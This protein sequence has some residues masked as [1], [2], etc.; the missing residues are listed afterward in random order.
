MIRQAT[1]LRVIRFAILL[2]AVVIVALEVRGC[3]RHTIPAQDQSMDPTYPGG[4]RVIV[5]HLAPGAPL[6]RGTDVLY[7]MEQGGTTYERFGRVQAIAGDEVGS[8]DGKLTVNGKP[9]GPIPIPGE[10]KGRV[11][12]GTVFI[13][14]INPAETRYP[15]SR[16]LGF[17][18]RDKVLGVIRA[19][20]R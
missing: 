11:P 20:I 15:D 12:E 3:A 4:T 6:D 17:I 2:A 14:A 19:S 18:R 10:A 5:D 13:L 16:T 1:A 8:A 9:V 7:T